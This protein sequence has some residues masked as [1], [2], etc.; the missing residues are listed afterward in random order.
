MKG[1]PAS[2]DKRYVSNG[3][4]IFISSSFYCLFSFLTSEAVEWFSFCRRA[5]LATTYWLSSG[6]HVV[7]ALLG[8]GGA[9][10]QLHQASS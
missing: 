10:H 1:L 8:F 2:K 3:N 9:P 4:S 5:P 7:L 6:F